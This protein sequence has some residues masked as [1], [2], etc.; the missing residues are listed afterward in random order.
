M[1]MRLKMAK[2]KSTY[3]SVSVV[4]FLTVFLGGCE[5]TATVK[6]VQK[7]AVKTAGISASG[8]RMDE[9]EKMERC[10]R[11]LESL[12]KIDAAVYNKRKAEFDRLMSGASLY[13]GVRNDVHNYTQGAVD[14]LYRFR[15]D[16]L[17]ADISHEVLDGLSR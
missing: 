6:P 5:N 9:V 12:K 4:L 1:R 8:D 3:K 17:C 7:N 16:K 11:E 2:N 10:R 13:N 14:A 15:A